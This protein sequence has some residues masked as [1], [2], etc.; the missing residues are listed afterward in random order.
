[1]AG[2]ARLRLRAGL[3]AGPVAR[4][5]G[6]HRRNADLGFGAARRLFERDL[7][8][9]AQV[10]AAEDGRAP[11]ARAAEDLAEDV[12]EDV[13]EVAAH[14]GARAG[15]RMRID[16]RVP[17][18]IVRRALLRVAEH[19]VGFLRFLEVLLGARVLRIAVRMP[20]HGE[21]PV[22]LLQLVFRSVAVDAEHFVVVA[23][24]HAFGFHTA[25]T[26]SGP[27][28][29]F[30]SFTSVNS[31]STTLLSSFLPA[32]AWPCSWPAA[33]CAPACALAC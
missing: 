30:L 25:V 7:E 32:S 17:E 26:R 15:S 14:A 5:A 1:M 22:G 12:A 21:A 29:A 2:L 9:V 33:P 8:V 16:A 18:L 3:G 10:R 11:A 23:L 27:Q 4:V 20:F 24:R 13:A 28:P 31:A 19:L 6:L